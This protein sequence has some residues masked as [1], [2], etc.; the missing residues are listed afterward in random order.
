MA[1]CDKRRWDE[2]GT[3]RRLPKWAPQCSC[4]LGALGLLQGKLPAAPLLSA[5]CQETEVW[6][7]VNDY[8]SL[9]AKSTILSHFLKQAE[10][11]GLRFFGSIFSW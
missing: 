6:Q 1:G 9:C 11:K 2:Q 5:E 8:P 3:T 4:T 7:T 10:S